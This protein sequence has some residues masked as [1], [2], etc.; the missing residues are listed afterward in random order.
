MRHVIQCLR[1]ALRYP[2]L[3]LM[4][5]R[6]FRGSVGMTYGIY[7]M[8]EAYDAGRELAHLVTGRRYES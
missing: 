7:E 5:A 4:G 8:Q 6:E 1:Y 3:A 2:R